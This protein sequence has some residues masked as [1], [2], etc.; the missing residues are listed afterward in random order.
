[1][2]TNTLDSIEPGGFYFLQVNEDQ[3][4]VEIGGMTMDLYAGLNPVQW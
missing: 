2:A 3:M 4:G 1:M